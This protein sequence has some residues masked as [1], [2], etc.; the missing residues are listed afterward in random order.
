MTYD[1]ELKK[2]EMYWEGW[3]STLG[4]V[5]VDR[6]R[7]YNQEEYQLYRSAIK[8]VGTSKLRTFDVDMINHESLDTVHARLEDITRYMRRFRKD[9]HK[10]DSEY[11][12]KE[13][14]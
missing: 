9:M 11:K 2:L 3:G 14:K 13:I 5:R 4:V 8:Y 12:N 7:T 1:P 6:D 10:F